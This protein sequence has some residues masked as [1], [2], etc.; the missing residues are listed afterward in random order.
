MLQI[1]TEERRII[2]LSELHKFL[3]LASL[4]S[5]RLI[6]LL[7]PGSIVFGAQ[8][9]KSHWDACWGSVRESVRDPWKIS[10]KNFLKS[11]PFPG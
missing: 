4:R 9:T 8:T 2:P 5:L 7:F 1:I 3:P 6:Q 11:S 10:Q